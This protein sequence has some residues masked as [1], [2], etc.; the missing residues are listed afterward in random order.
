[1]NKT[2][3]NISILYLCCFLSSLIIPSGLL[4]QRT[5]SGDHDMVRESSL[6]NSGPI[7]KLLVYHDRD[8]YLE[9]DTIWLKIINTDLFSG[10]TIGLSSAAYV[11]L[12]GPGEKMFARQ[13]IILTNEAGHGWIRI[14]ENILSGNYYLRTYTSWMKNYH[15][16]G[17]TYSLISIINPFIPLYFSQYETGNDK[18]A[19]IDVELFPEGGHIIYGIENRI[20]LRL[21]GMITDNDS[22]RV[23]IR[24]E[25][26]SMVT[27]IKFISREYG[28][29]SLA[30]LETK[31]YYL[32]VMLNGT[33]HK[34]VPLPQAQKEGYTMDCIEKPD[35]IALD[36]R[37]HPPSSLD[38]QKLWLTVKASGQVLFSEPADLENGAAEVMIN[39][40]QLKNGINEF[41]LTDM[42]GNRLCSKI[43]NRPVPDLLTIEIDLEKER[44][45]CRD[46][47]RF[48][49][50][51]RDMGGRAVKSNLS[52]SVYLV[53]AAS[54]D[55]EKNPGKMDV[56]DPV[57]FTQWINTHRK[58]GDGIDDGTL[59]AAL[60][61]GYLIH[62]ARNT[63][64]EELSPGLQY[65]PELA[66]PA[67]SG[68]VIE[69]TSGLPA[70]NRLI[71]CSSMGSASEFQVF[72]TGKDGKFRFARA[73]DQ[74][75]NDLVFSALNQEILV[76]IKIDNPYSDQY[77]HIILPALHLD[78][79]RALY[80][81]QL[82]LNKQ[83]RIAYK[84]I[85]EGPPFESP[86]GSTSFFYGE[87]SETVNLESF[88]KLPVMEEIFRE[89]VKTVIVYRK[90]GTFKLG[91][92][93]DAT[94]EIIGEN[95]IFLLDGVPMFDHG[96]ILEID[97]ALIRN[98]HV[99]DSKYFIGDLEMDGIIDIRSRQGQFQD[100][101]LPPSTV[102]YKFQ[103]YA[104]YD[105]PPTGIDRIPDEASDNHLPDFRNLL[106]WNPDIST[107]NEG[108][109]EIS[110][111]AADVPGQY[112]IVV[113]GISADGYTGISTTAVEIILKD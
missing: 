29:F 107:D 20:V 1:M 47:I 112:R 35:L 19:E 33:R 80:I 81:E 91:V 18:P 49:V 23:E 79:S 34:R 72:K 92:I 94:R 16:S 77:L 26:D 104:R 7:E 99:V 27:R 88:I 67:V 32:S 53:D 17:Y 103:S 14:P 68:I 84:N 4:A 9:G 3:K 101:I 73:K 22:L 109:A 74:E 36:I 12:I 106:Y 75:C 46:N 76:D 30:P 71:I 5:G 89:I 54:A 11:E 42:K 50:N 25:N 8:L 38:S 10:K 110:F 28:Y 39:S 31:D 37:K 52:A 60:S 48:S 87:P 113:K 43:I 63:S 82:S 56:M 40:A 90:S 13:K 41:M 15:P 69:K 98:I 96:R 83:V 21:S 70:G 58:E 59:D 85:N 111:D 95:P 93:D 100:F 66:V 2:C 102:T 57:L 24:D 62:S 64:S 97:P 108:K 105:N 55:E 45:M 44:F 65:Y 6:P 86:P 78:E 51:V 61:A